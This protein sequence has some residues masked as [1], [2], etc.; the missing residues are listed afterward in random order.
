MSCDGDATVSHI[1]RKKR[2]KR[3]N[4]LDCIGMHGG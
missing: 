4:I 1:T 3:N 2:M